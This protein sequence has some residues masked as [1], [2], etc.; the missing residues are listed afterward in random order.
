MSIVSWQSGE[1]SVLKLILPFPPSVN[2]LWRISQ[3]NGMYRSEKYTQ[4]RK[5][6]LWAILGQAKKQK[7]PG[8]Y[9]LEIHA[10]KPDKRR[11]DLGN[12]EKS[13]SDILQA[14]G[15]IEDDSLCQEIHLR[16]VKEG[17]ECL[18]MIGAYNGEKV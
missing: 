8:E 6:A 5:H 14:A 1:T 18:I 17:P 3:N 10:V 11:R 4:W 9:V 7:I 12:L 15:V 2:R 13:I 16:W